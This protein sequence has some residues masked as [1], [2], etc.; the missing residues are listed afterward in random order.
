[1]ASGHV[2]DGPVFLPDRLER[3]PCGDRPGLAD[4]PVGLILVGVRLPAAGFLVERLVMPH[5][6]G[7]GIQERCRR[8]S[9]PWVKAEGANRRM[10][11]PKVQAL[12][13]GLFVAALLL[14]ASVVVLGTIRYRAIHGIAVV[15][16]LL[17]GEQ[18]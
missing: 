16:S 7:L 18:A 6:H 15:L 3:D 11:L 1:M 5:T 14:K 17:P 13:E 2:A 12:L 10:V 8:A 4:G 9:D